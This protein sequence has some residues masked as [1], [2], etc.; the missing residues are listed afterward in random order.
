MKRL[1]LQ[2][3]SSVS[4]FQMS[5]TVVLSACLVVLAG[6]VAGVAA[7][8]ELLPDGSSCTGQDA[9]EF[10]DPLDCSSYYVCENDCAVHKKCER[11]FLFD[12]VREYCNY[13][14]DVECADRPCNDPSHCI[15]TTT[16]STTTTTEDCGHVKD[17]TGI[18]D[19]YYPDP[20]N[21]RKYWHCFEE[22]GEHFLCDDNMMYDPVNVWCDTPERVDCDER[23]VCDICDDNCFSATPPP[24][25]SPE[26]GHVLDCSGLADGWYPDPYNCRKYWHCFEGSGD[27][28]MCEGDLLYD[29]ANV[30]CNH[31]ESVDCGDR[32]ICNVCDE[33]CVTE[34][35]PTP[36]CDHILDCTN[37]QDGWYEDPFNCR[38][39]WHCD[40]G[41]GEH[42]MC[43]GNLLYDP[44]NRWCDYPERVNCNG[45]PICD[46]CDENC[47]N[48]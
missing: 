38:K 9:K 32:P 35:P 16:R 30:W 40:H 15:T 1:D 48:F 25:T 18:A 6:V 43:E 22:E 7:D 29:P 46:Q 41:R 2:R 28:L 17:C 21:C 5:R 12:S 37:R 13:P 47:S 4:G 10:A 8:C 20:Y 39:Y 34:P 44:Y 26:C 3:I 14:L 33:D 24:P 42:Y 45:R 11:N 23:P 31:P 36:P 27:H 19:G